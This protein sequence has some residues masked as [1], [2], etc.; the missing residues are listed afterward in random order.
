MRFVRYVC[1]P[2]VLG[3]AG[4]PLPEPRAP[5]VTPKA[6]GRVAKPHAAPAERDMAEADGIDR[7]QPAVSGQDER[8][9]SDRQ[10]AA[11]K[12][13]IALYQQFLERAGDDPHF[14]E[15]VERSRDRIVDAQQT[16]EFLSSQ[17]DER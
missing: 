17:R 16:I 6:A 13:A 9:S 7:D 14:A 10:I 8:F 5:D 2:L 4:A 1:V 15:A 12:R 11:L 3:C